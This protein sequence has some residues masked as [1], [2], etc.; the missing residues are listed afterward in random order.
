[1]KSCGMCGA[2]F[3]PRASSSLY[4]SDDCR[5]GAQ[6]LRTYN[7]RL[8]KREAAPKRTCKQ[9]GEEFTP[10]R[11]TEMYCSRICAAKAQG[12]KLAP[13]P[14]G[15]PCRRCF[16]WRTMGASEYCDYRD[17]HGG[18]GRGCPA[19]DCNKFKPRQAAE[20]DRL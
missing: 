8:R 4:C 7:Y 3:A 18:V 20:R 5:K 19:D 1:M 15:G 2:E 11:S 9:C 17:A 16:W 6:R 13:L 10:R 12:I 14:Y